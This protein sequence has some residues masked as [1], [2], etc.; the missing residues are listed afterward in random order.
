MTHKP[1]EY[2]DVFELE[3]PMREAKKRRLEQA[4]ESE[5]EEKWIEEKAKERNEL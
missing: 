3:R 2:Y 5:Q 4:R 1:I